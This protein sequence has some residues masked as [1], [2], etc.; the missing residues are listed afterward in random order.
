MTT[1]GHNDEPQLATAST[2]GSV[3]NGGQDAQN[4]A[5]DGAGNSQARAG[6]VLGNCYDCSDPVSEDDGS[7]FDGVYLHHDC[8]AT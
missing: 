3:Q 4:G 2:A 5:L 8:E 1:G 6:A 7:G